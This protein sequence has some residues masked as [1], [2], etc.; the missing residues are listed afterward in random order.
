MYLISPTGETET[1]TLSIKK[2][3]YDINKKG[4]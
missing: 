3:T 1:Y 4:K 2:D